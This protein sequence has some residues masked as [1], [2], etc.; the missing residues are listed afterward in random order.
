MEANQSQR[1]PG[2]HTGNPGIIK[3]KNLGKCLSSTKGEG[4]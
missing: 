2:V 4:T 1:R 3:I